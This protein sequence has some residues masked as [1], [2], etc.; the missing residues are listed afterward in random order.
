MT[1]PQELVLAK[2]L[3][4]EWI[5]EEKHTGEMA[6]YSIACNTLGIDEMV[7]WRLL[8]LLAKEMEKE[9]PDCLD[10]QNNQG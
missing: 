8:S 6:A 7:G 10:R 3:N 1:T 2:E 5:S 4:E 9:N